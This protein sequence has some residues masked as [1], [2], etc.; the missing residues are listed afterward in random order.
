MASRILAGA[1]PEAAAEWK[2][3]VVVVLSV[4]PSVAGTFLEVAAEGLTGGNG[5]SDQRKGLVAPHTSTSNPCIVGSV[6]AW[7]PG[8]ER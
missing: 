1:F 6:R 8:P 3:D 5:Q 2:F 7:E 4:G